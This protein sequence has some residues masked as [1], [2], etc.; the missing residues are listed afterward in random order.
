[1][2]HNP[3]D[4]EATSRLK[5]IFNTMIDGIIIINEKGTIDALNPSAARL[6]GYTIEEL[7]GQNV[8]VLMPSPHREGH[9]TYLQNYLSGGEAKIIGKGREVEGKRKDGSLFPMRLAVGE[10]HMDKVHRY[11]TGIIHDL[12]EMKKVEDSLRVMNQ[13]LEKM[14]EKRTI[15]LTEAINKLL[16]IN[17]KYEDEIEQRKDTELI[18]KEHQAKLMEMLEKQK[19]LNDL[20][21]RFVS[22]ASHEFRTPLSTILSSIALIARYGDLSDFDKQQKHID[23]IKT[24]VKH[25]NSILSD[26]LSLSRVEESSFKI[27]L[28]TFQI[29]ELLQEVNMDMVGSLKKGQR[30]I[31]EE[32]EPGKQMHS[33]KRILK[34]VLFNLLSNSIKYSD[35]GSEIKCRSVQLEGRNALEIIDKGIGIPLED[36][37]H[38]FTRFFRASNA[39]NI[40]GTGLGLYIV[41]K[42]LEA[43]DGELK[44]ESEFG[45]GSTFTILF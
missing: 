29:A 9:D 20:K 1:M 41:K 35:E 12:S 18:L 38:L 45:K 27:N 30:I 8:N 17:Q 5:A 7:R 2:K 3:Q 10:V 22:M 16:E 42:Y 14:V 25:L 36:Q 13:G 23:R 28:E 19:E 11:F 39:I 37:K 26:F 44:M 24:S 34:A 15:K 6:F 40:K 33:D 21:S 4:N 32:E 43:L 31:M